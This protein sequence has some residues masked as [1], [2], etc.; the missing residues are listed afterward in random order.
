M[1]FN[2][3]TIY[4]L[5]VAGNK[6]ITKKSIK[7]TIKQ[8]LNPMGTIIRFNRFEDF[9]KRH[10][11]ISKQVYYHSNDIKLSD[12]DILFLGSDQIWNPDITDG[13][14]YFYFGKIGN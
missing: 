4:D 2:S 6:R 14:E 7:R 10:M 12:T 1:L 5:D 11:N 13:F 9:R 3:F 8:F